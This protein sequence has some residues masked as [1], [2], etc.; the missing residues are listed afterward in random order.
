MDLRFPFQQLPVELQIRVLMNL[1]QGTLRE[2]C[3][4]NREFYQLCQDES[5]LEKLYYGMEAKY[6]IRIQRLESNLMDRIQYLIGL[7]KPRLCQTFIS[8]YYEGSP[9]TSD[10]VLNYLSTGHAEVINCLIEDYNQGLDQ[11]KIYLNTL[12][13]S[14]EDY[15]P[16]DFESYIPILNGTY[17]LTYSDLFKAYFRSKYQAEGGYKSAHVLGFLREIVFFDISPTSN[18]KTLTLFKQVK[19]KTPTYTPLLTISGTNVDDMYNVI[20]DLANNT[21]KLQAHWNPSI[22]HNI[23]NY[24]ISELRLGVQKTLLTGADVKTFIAAQQTQ[25]IIRQGTV[26][27]CSKPSEERKRLNLLSDRREAAKAFRASLPPP[28]PRFFALQGSLPLY[29]E[30]SLFERL[31]LQTQ[32]TQQTSLIS[33]YSRPQIR[34][35]SGRALP[36]VPVSS[37]QT[38]FSPQRAWPTSLRPTSPRQHS[39]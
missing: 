1:P 34:R 32:Q 21:G 20:A 25:F 36:P 31:P 13:E 38:Q 10:I 9:D 30:E 7:V 12:I 29:D 33:S 11:A 19:S 23:N 39:K 15:Y 28:D 8:E 17:I 3:Q 35:P 14:I 2:F 16:L 22:K 37:L 4:T 5:L 6:G 24:L 18:M 26:V 27:D